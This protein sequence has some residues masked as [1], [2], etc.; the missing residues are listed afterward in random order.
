MADAP[1]VPLAGVDFK[2][3]VASAEAVRETAY[4]SWKAVQT[5]GL[6]EPL[7]DA[8]LRDAYDN[9]RS[10]GEWADYVWELMIHGGGLGGITKEPYK[11][12]V[13]HFQETWIYQRLHA[14]HES[15]NMALADGIV[16]A[17]TF[18]LGALG[19]TKSSETVEKTWEHLKAGT[20]SGKAPSTTAA[21]AAAAAALPP[22]KLTTPEAAA[23]GGLI[24]LLLLL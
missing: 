6:P 8:F 3:L 13:A 12:W 2:A 22:P 24:V 23:I 9:G 18:G 19:A 20:T 7:P 15:G 1:G 5:S 16:A 10:A 14:A 17:F 4:Q 21:A 11:S